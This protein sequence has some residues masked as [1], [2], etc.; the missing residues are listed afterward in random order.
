MLSPAIFI[1]PEEGVTSR[2]KLLKVVLFPAPFTPRSAKHS[3]R[4]RPNESLLTATSESETQ[5]VPEGT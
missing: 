2:I 4:V 5:V 1:N 3:P